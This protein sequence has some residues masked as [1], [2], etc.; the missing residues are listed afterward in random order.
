M[1]FIGPLVSVSPTPP[2]PPPC[3]AAE[4]S[5]QSHESD[6]DLGD[7]NRGE[8]KREAEKR[9][10]DEGRMSREV[11]VRECFRFLLLVGLLHTSLNIS[12]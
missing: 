4:I 10:Q 5:H 9:G 2:P 12:Q 8:G 6:N 3:G 7:N 1:D 11:V